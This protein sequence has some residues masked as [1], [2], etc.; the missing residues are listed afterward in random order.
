MWRKRNPG[1]LWM[2]MYIDTYMV[3]NHTEVLK[4]KNGTTI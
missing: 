4:I 1:A 3:E 2:G